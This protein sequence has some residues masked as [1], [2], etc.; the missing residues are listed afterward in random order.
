MAKPKTWHKLA[1]VASLLALAALVYLAL[2]GPA[3]ELSAGQRREEEEREA[4]KWGQ[5]DVGS[6]APA[7]AEP[8][9]ASSL[10]EPAQTALDGGASSVA[11]TSFG[12]RPPSE[13]PSQPPG[14]VEEP[15]LGQ[16]EPSPVDGLSSAGAQ[17]ANETGQTS[18][19]TPTSTTS[20]TTTSAPTS[21]PTST[22]SSTVAPNLHSDD[23]TDPEPPSGFT[24]RTQLELEAWRQFK[25]AYKRTYATKEEQLKREA[26]FLANR[27]FIMN[28]NEQQ[29]AAFSLAVNHFA[30]LTRDE[31]N[32]LYVGPQ[33]SWTHTI[34]QLLLPI[35]PPIHI[36]SEQSG[37]GGQSVDWRNTLGEVLD[38]GT[39]RE[40]SVF[41]ALANVE[42]NY[43]AQLL[44]NSPNAPP[45]KLSERQ[46]LDCLAATPTPPGSS[47]VCS[48]SSSM[49][50]VFDLLQ[51]QPAA[52]LSTAQNY[53]DQLSRQPGGATCDVAPADLPRVRANAYVVVHRDNIPDALLNSGPLTVALDASQSTFHFYSSGLYHDQNCST[54]TY[55]QHLLLVG[56][57]SAPEGEPSQAHYLARN[58]FGPKWGESGHVRL[59]KDE[60][61]N[62]CL[63]QNLA[64]YP[65]L[66]P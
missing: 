50:Q 6:A 4:K 41:A 65:N 56:Y 21:T 28:F 66:A 11:S 57:S 7:L 17:A 29:G 61:R 38:Q 12:R 20:T 45:V 55:N 24:D 5:V 1:A 63:P 37:P 27:R 34:S 60:R 2:D 19:P 33:T 47:P 54:D 3:P 59:L 64:I 43:N 35:P 40:S 52:G 16:S 23:E 13:R 51:H 53:L 48:G 46:V 32:Q 15:A 25:L 49:V 58:S 9:P 39:C 30:D 22:S 18:A 42:S 8:R 14:Q 31:I 62:K 44:A 10:E 36:L 26:I